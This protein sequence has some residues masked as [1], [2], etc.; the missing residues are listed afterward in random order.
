MAKEEFNSDVIKMSVSNVLEKI[1]ANEAPIEVVAFYERMSPK[2]FSFW[3][4]GFFVALCK[5]RAVRNSEFYRFL[6][7][8]LV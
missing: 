6:K 5:K 8:Q 2:D 1:R 7:K 3:A 4:H